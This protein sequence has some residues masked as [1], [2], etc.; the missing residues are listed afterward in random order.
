MAGVPQGS[1][2]SPVLFNFFVSSYPQGTHLTGSYADDFTDSVTCRNYTDA[3]P[4]LTRQATKVHQWAGER[5]LTLSAL[6]STVTLFTSWNTEVNDHPD[7]QLNNSPLPLERN[8]RIL[9]VTFDPRLNFSSHIENLRTRAGPRLNIMKALSGTTWGQQAETLTMTYKLLVRSILNYAAPVWFPNAASSNILKLQRIQN[10]ALRVAT[11]CTKRTPI[12]HLHEETK[13]LPIKDHLGMLCKQFL[14][15]ALQPGNASHAAVTSYPGPKNIRHTLRSAFFDRDF[16]RKYTDT[17]T[18]TGVVPAESYK[19]TIKDIHTDSVNKALDNLQPNK[20]LNS[21]P[22][23]VSTDEQSLPRAYRTT[24][25]R[26][27]SGY[28]PALNNYQASIDTST[29]D[30]CPSCSLAAHTTAHLF[31]CPEHPTTLEPLDLWRR[32]VEVA[33]F[34]AGLPGFS[35]PSRRPPPEPEPPPSH[36][37]G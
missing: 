33:D 25:S 22:P 1:C 11:G 35:L 8:P 20:V 3:S 19:K 26:L 28:C 30:R 6:K 7:V 32:P 18:Y 9:G 14:A 2:I 27:R 24:L 36:L 5:G 17:G 23:L 37:D 12:D 31:S 10:S 4:P 13:V 34:V 15:R 29:T 16:Q 21:R